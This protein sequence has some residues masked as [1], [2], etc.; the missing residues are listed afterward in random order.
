MTGKFCTWAPPPGFV[1]QYVFIRLKNANSR[2]ELNMGSWVFITLHGVYL[3]T[4]YPH[5]YNKLSEN[6]LQ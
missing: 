3:S 4:G 2:M 1:R 6:T 5:S